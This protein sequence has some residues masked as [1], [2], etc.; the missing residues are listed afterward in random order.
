[1]FFAFRAQKVVFMKALEWFRGFGVGF[2]QRFPFERDLHASLQPL[3]VLDCAL[4]L[5]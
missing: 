4:L 5:V 2:V 3:F 1:M